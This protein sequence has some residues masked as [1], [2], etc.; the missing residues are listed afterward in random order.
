VFV[1]AISACASTP[2]PP[3]KVAPPTDPFDLELPSEAPEPNALARLPELWEHE[4]GRSLLRL[5][6]GPLTGAGNFNDIDGPLSSQYIRNSYLVSEENDGARQLVTRL[7]SDSARAPQEEANKAF[8]AGRFD[9][10]LTS[11]QQ[12]IERDPL[13]AK[14]YFYVAEIQAQRHDLEAATAWN[15]RGLR[16]SPRDAYGYALRAEILLL[17]GRDEE[18]RG[19]LAYA[20]ALDP[21]SPRGIKLLKRLG[22]TRQPGIEPPIYIKRA[23]DQKATLIARGG[24]HEAWRRYAV[25]RALLTHDA[26][27]RAEFVQSPVQERLPGTRSL[28]EET[29]CGYLATAAYRGPRGAGPDKGAAPPPGQAQAQAQS[30]GRSGPPDADLERWSQAYDANLLREAIIYETVGC[31]RPDVLP[32]LPDEVLGR[33]IE[34]VRLF[35]LPRPGSPAAAGIQPAAS[36]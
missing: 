13:F 12:V 27:I 19:A 26:R 32:L 24:G 2:P 11:Y 22:G 25:C 31:R 1:F 21:Y 8:T 30:S 33:M 34:Y 17:M 9:D 28:E 3:P 5:D 16:L 14:P 7:P 4:A 6:T 20:L 29:A 35:V 15:D 36:H 23:P 18:A 10:A